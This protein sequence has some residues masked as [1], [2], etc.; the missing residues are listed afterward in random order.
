MPTLTATDY[1]QICGLVGQRSAHAADNRVRVSCNRCGDFEWAPLVPW[2]TPIR[3]TRQ[4]NLSAFVREQNAVGIVPFLNNE[5]IKK[6]E[7]RT[8]PPLRDRALRALAAIVQE[9]GYDLNTTFSVSDKLRIHALS[10][11]ADD[12]ELSVLLEILEI[13]GLIKTAGLVPTTVRVTPVGLIQAEELARSGTEFIQG[14]VAMSF[15]ASMNE[16]YTLG[17][18]PGI[19]SAG[20]RPFRIDGKEHINGIS[21]EILAEIRR[22]RFLVADYTQQNNGVY[23]EAGVAIGLGIPVIP[24]CRADQLDKLHFDIR[25]INTLKWETPAQL[26]RDLAKRISGAIGDG[27]LRVEVA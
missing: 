5:L 25:H 12:L 20:Y 9:I 16:A 26:A 8:R 21:D 7:S 3:A 1:C 22:S 18:D 6:V 24:T 2:P 15:D 19:R 17:F 27:P 10:Y 11:S 23:F 14:F 13:D 4:V